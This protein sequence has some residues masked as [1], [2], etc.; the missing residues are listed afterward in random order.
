MELTKFSSNAG[1]LLIKSSRALLAVVLMAGFARADSLNFL[2]NPEPG[3]LVATFDFDG[4]A[5]SPV[6]IHSQYARITDG[7]DSIDGSKA[8]VARVV[9]DS[10]KWTVCFEVKPGLMKP[11]HYYR[12]SFDYKLLEP[13][14]EKAHPYFY[15][16]PRNLDGRQ[17]APTIDGPVHVVLRK[18]YEVVPAS[19]DGGQFALGIRGR[20]AVAVDNIRIEELPKLDTSVPT[21][22]DQ[23][24]SW[25]NFAG[26]CT[27]MTRMSFYKTEKEVLALLDRMQA[28]GVGWLRTDFAWRNLFPDSFDTHDA[29]FMRRIEFVVDETNR[30]GMR[31]VAILSAPP[32]WA[33][34]HPNARSTLQYPA[35]NMADYER[36]VRFMA[37]KFKGRIHVWEIGN[38]PNWYKFW[39]APFSD[40]LDQLHA[41]SRVLR[42]VDT[43]NYILNGGL[44]A[45]G[46]VGMWGANVSALS[47][48]LEPRNAATYDA[49][50]VHAYPS[51]PDE[52]LYMVNNITALM[53]EKGVDKRVWVTE[54][55]YPVANK[56]TEQGQADFMEALFLKLAAHPQ[57]DAVFIYNARC[58]IPPENEFER[59]LGILNTDLTPRPSYDRLRQ[60]FSK[61]VPAKKPELGVKKI[62]KLP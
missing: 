38:E 17:T 34:T 32:R 23:D 12:V 45:T 6:K 7:A 21:V 30:R 9:E 37:E 36:Y 8:L 29:E 3:R 22:I 2:S 42:A 33:S 56:V 57:I 60:I 31:I 55:G 26:V 41:G 51:H 24:A 46:F 50:S 54:T 49:L 13:V 44:A 28:L 35:K 20:G 40:Y 15:T 27:H 11:Y 16:K 47:D 19:S 1:R 62:S 53:R 39:L 10:S 43:Q 59:G 48:L 5:P 14:A 61:P 58:K 25:K 52:W 4:E 18:V